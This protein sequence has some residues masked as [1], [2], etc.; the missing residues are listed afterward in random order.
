MKQKLESIINKGK[1][2]ALASLAF[3]TVNCQ[4]LGY[5]E[6]KVED[7]FESKVKRLVG[8]SAEFYGYINLSD[9]LSNRG[10]PPSAEYF[11]GHDFE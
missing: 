11:I 6:P 10:T 7:G 5:T 3:L 8:E 4:P 1:I 2:F 9:G